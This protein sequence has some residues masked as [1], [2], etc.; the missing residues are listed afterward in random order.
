MEVKTYTLF[1][2]LIKK[3]DKI[4]IIKYSQKFYSNSI[5]LLN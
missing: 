4:K 5:L 2:S 1:K 3:I